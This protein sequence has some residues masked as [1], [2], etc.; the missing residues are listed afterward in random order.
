M[1]TLDEINNDRHALK[2][3]PLTQLQYDLAVAEFVKRQGN[4]IDP[5]EFNQVMVVFDDPV[6]AA[7]A[8]G[9]GEDHGQDRE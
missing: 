8:F 1:K 9:I 4:L 6:P 3:K 5:F 7:A 2:K